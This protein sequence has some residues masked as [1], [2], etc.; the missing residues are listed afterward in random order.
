MAGSRSAN[1][2]EPAP[3]RR[4]LTV[5]LTLLA[6]HP[7]ASADDDAQAPQLPCPSDD[8]TCRCAREATCWDLAFLSSGKTTRLG[9]TATL[10]STALGDVH[11]LETGVLVSYR[12]DAYR[13]RGLLNSHFFAFGALGA[14]SAGTEG[15]LAGSIDFGL[16]VPMSLVSGP[17][18]RIGPSGWLLGHDAL[19]L[20][21]LEPLRLS[22]G[23]QRLIGDALL[24]GGLTTGVLGH[25]RFAAAGSS[26]GLA[27][28]LEI[29]HY[30]AAHVGMFLFDGRLIYVQPGPF[31]SASE[32]GI[33][34]LEGCV[35]PRPIAA[36]LDVR[37]VQSR[38][39]ARVRSPGRAARETARVLY[40]GLTLG[41]TP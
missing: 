10:T 27:G 12:A 39:P 9:V 29:G 30:L 2:I 35:Y 20:S 17:V 7:T 18:V 33:V 1:W 41:L 31:G 24:E 25:G 13:A 4:V 22:A 40:G 3:R 36:C 23:F 16:R 6:A 28:A 5:L 37:Y 34:Q 15:A 32:V 21:M 8:E 14:G 26:T 19:Q 38:L 11:R